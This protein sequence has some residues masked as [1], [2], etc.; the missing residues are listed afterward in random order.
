M[1]EEELF[2]KQDRPVMR[3]LLTQASFI[4]IIH[5]HHSLES[6]ISIIHHHHSSASFTSDDSGS[7]V[8]YYLFNNIYHY[9]PRKIF[10]CLNTEAQIKRK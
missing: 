7:K 5:Q 9:I 10:N 8:S 2:M 6:F 1:I 4:S 3:L